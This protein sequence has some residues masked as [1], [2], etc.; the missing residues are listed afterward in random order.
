MIYFSSHQ[1][2]YND[3]S[4]NVLSWARYVTV[5]YQT[6][7]IEQSSWAWGTGKRKHWFIY[8]QVINVIINNW[9]FASYNNQ[10]REDE[11]YL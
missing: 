6:E 8:F 3:L 10:A 1:Q 9:I 5:S 7:M 11:E 2:F 4:L